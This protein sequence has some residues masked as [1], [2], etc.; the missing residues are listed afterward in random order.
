M[1]ILFTVHPGAGHLRPMAPLA[2][3]L[4]R[5]GHDVRVAA[6]PAFVEAVSSAGLF[7]A[8]AGLAWLESAADIHLPGF[9]DADPIAGLAALFGKPSAGIATDVLASAGDWSPDLVVRDNTELGGWVV[10]NVLDVP[11]VVFGVV[12]RLPLPA[13]EAFAQQ[14]DELRTTFPQ[15]ARAD[16]ASTY[17][18]LY[19]EPTPPALL[20]SEPAPGQLLIRPAVE[21]SNGDR[22]PEWLGQLG[23]RRVVYLTLGTVFHRKSALLDVLL[24]ALATEDVDVVL[25]Y[26]AQEV[27]LGL[28]ANVKAAPFIAQD[29]ILP[30]CSAVVCH[31]GRGSVMGAL[32]HGLPLVLVPVAADQPLTAAA[33]QRAGVAK[34]VATKHLQFPGGTMPITVPEQLTVTA[35]RDAVRMVLD[36]RA[37]AGAAAAVQAQMAAMPS[38]AETAQAVERLG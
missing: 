11:L 35:V 28:P 36:D 6:S 33:C 7:H 37:Y 23:D 29:L 3:E 9:T 38:V 4:G 12:E 24:E 1:K 10:A 30:L 5:R 25:T 27:P 19:L 15:L 13:M 16:A 21:V 34:V 31:A 17:G 2:R 22:A 18:D 26:G 8:P 14:L 32:A 20:S